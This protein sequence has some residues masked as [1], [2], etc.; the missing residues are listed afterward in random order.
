MI[1]SVPANPTD[2]AVGEKVR[3]QRRILGMS[4]TTL[5]DALGVSYQQV[6][7]YETGKNRIGASRL[8]AIANILGVPV[9]FFFSEVVVSAEL[10][11][12]ASNDNLAEFIA[13]DEG[14]ELNRAFFRIGDARLRRALVGMVK[15]VAVSSSSAPT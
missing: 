8:Q 6:Q 9:T 10:S 11:K 2:K 15:T 13:S 3:L 5:S 4:Q 1:D 14:M 12:G 7:K